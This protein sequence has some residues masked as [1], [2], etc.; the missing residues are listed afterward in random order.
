MTIQPIP[1]KVACLKCKNQGFYLK[2]SYTTDLFLVFNQNEFSVHKPL[3]FKIQV[4]LPIVGELQRILSEAPNWNCSKCGELT[5]SIHISKLARRFLH[6]WEREYLGV[7]P[8][9][10]VVYQKGPVI[11]LCKYCQKIARLNEKY[12]LVCSKCGS[13]KGICRFLWDPTSEHPAM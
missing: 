1:V 13:T 2:S 12:E 10:I 8:D 4:T 3:G 7:N 9:Y 11:G 6:F 5:E